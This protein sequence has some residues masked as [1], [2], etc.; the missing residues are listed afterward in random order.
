MPL[1][2]LS[3]TGSAGR[4]VEDVNPAVP[5]IMQRLAASGVCAIADHRDALFLRLTNVRGPGTARRFR[6][7]EPIG[8]V[9]GQQENSTH[10][11]F[12][13]AELQYVSNN[14]FS[15]A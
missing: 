13:P 1:T 11:T 15:A 6:Q 4:G 9:R 12:N 3:G 14:L 5:Q 7:E 2:L 10:I 8:E